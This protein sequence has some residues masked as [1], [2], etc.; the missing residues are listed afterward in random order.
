MIGSS[1]FEDAEVEGVEDGLFEVV[2]TTPLAAVWVFPLATIG[3]L[4]E[5]DT[6][7]GTE[8]VELLLNAHKREKRIRISIYF[9]RDDKIFLL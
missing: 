9:E 2:A 8:V 7:G 3:E 1:C 4:V 5:V 6:D